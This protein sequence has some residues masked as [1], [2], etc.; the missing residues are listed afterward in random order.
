[1]AIANECLSMCVCVCV[2]LCV[3]VGEWLRVGGFGDSGPDTL[4][5]SAALLGGPKPANALFISRSMFAVCICAATSKGLMYLR[6]AACC[7]MCRVLQCVAVCCSV[8]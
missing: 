2:Y 7:S 4:L 3:W 8:L 6:V 1:M 5:W